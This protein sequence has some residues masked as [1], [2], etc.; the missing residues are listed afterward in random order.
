ME[1]ENLDISLIS[2][3]HLTSSWQII[4]S[5][6][7][8][9]I[10]CESSISAVDSPSDSDHAA[11]TSR[12]P[13]LILR[14]PSPDSPPCEITILFTQQHEIKQVYV[15]STARVYEIYCAADKKGD[16]EYLCT[17]RCGVAARIEE[18]LQDSDGIDYFSSSSSRSNRSS[19]EGHFRSESAGSANEDGWVD[20]E[21]QNPSVLNAGVSH[22]A[23][24]DV[25]C[26]E[27][28]NQE[29]FEATA[30][31]SDVDPVLSVTLRLLSI[32][33]GNDI[34]I[35]EIYVFADPVV[36][37]DISP[38]VSAQKTSS[39]S[40][41][42]SLLIPTLLNLSKLRRNQKQELTDSAVGQRKHQ[43]AEQRS[44]GEVTMPTTSQS[45]NSHGTVLNN[46]PVPMSKQD[47]AVQMLGS[48]NSSC[49]TSGGNDLSSSRI[50]KTLDELV[51]RVAKIEQYC[52]RFEENMLKPISNIETRL[53][54]VEQQLESFVETAKFSMTAHTKI[55]AP[56][57]SCIQSES[58]SISTGTI[59]SDPQDIAIPPLDANSNVS[60][61]PDDVLSSTTNQ[62]IPSLVVTAPDFSYV[63]DEGDIDTFEAVKDSPKGS[64]KKQ[65]SIDDALASALAGFISSASVDTDIVERPADISCKE[66]S[67]NS[68][69]SE[70][71]QP[72]DHIAPSTHID[73]CKERSANSCPSEI[74]QPD[75]HIAP[76]A[77]IDGGN[78]SGEDILV[79]EQESFVANNSIELANESGDVHNLLSEEGNSEKPSS[80][81]VSEV[82]ILDTVATD[83]SD[84]SM[85]VSSRAAD[86]DSNQIFGVASSD[87]SD[88]DITGPVFDVAADDMD[89]SSG[90]NA[91]KEC[92]A[93]LLNI[94]NLQSP[95]VLDF[96][97][98]ILD[99]KFSSQESFSAKSSL[100]ALLVDAPELH[101]EAP[102][103]E[104]DD[105]N[106]FSEQH[107]LI[108]IENVD[109]T[110]LEAPK[111]QSFC[112]D[113]FD[114]SWMPSNIQEQEPCECSI[115][116]LGASLI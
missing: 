79:T 38:S 107:D 85:D 32:Q 71:I 86:D 45:E 28:G 58:N 55:S 77:H 40:A 112:L 33:S 76:S 106:S 14:R 116:D 8:D 95:A 57:F 98:P 47:L 104:E 61:P 17:V 18:P 10:T 108:M 7:D 83:V 114:P 109:S 102:C 66:R 90:E 84:P 73:S 113:N 65:L 29:F 42:M 54:R 9:A 52:L 56:E 94:L 13:P 80:N 34:Y 24:K 21:V 64:A 46:A 37:T 115:H 51:S 31:I 68:C 72:D 39:A 11:I 1:T 3:K 36:S 53:E 48:Q 30:E 78:I 96:E 93:V 15:R 97:I 111:N 20:V 70:L 101:S 35:D 82:V 50:E 5:S 41:T 59:E 2:A 69:P 87:S 6:L 89:S 81:S 63:D 4:R 49:S 99:V 26:M 19:C 22:L 12:K 75:D 44:V 60:I 105:V 92:S 100:D 16:N 74:I 110:T 43:D 91:T 88:N 27:R 23:K 67:L 103:F 25:S 62:L